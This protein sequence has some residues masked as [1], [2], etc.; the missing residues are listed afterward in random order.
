MG[1]LVY[2]FFRTRTKFDFSAE[3]YYHCWIELPHRIIQIGNL[4]PSEES[5]FS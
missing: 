3:N 5:A 4:N 2:N 1:P